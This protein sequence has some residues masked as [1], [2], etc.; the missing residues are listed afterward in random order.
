MPGAPWAAV[1]GFEIAVS[2]LGL[3]QEFELTVSAGVG[4]HRDVPLAAVRGRRTPLTTDFQPTLQPL[5]VT[6]LGRSGSTWLMR[7]LNHHPAVVSYRPLEYESRVAAAWM[8]LVYSLAAPGRFLRPVA[9]TDIRDWNWWLAD[10]PAPENLPDVS[11]QRF[12][13]ASN[14]AAIAGFAQGRV[15][16]F[17]REVAQLDGRRPRYFAEKFVPD[18]ITA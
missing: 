4:E 18:Q 6:S 5:L 16:A 17:Y 12:L 14:V 13:A 11:V 15:E 9:G 7:L 8:Q 2:T 3:A 1:S 10:G